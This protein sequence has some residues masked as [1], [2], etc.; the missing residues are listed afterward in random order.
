MSDDYVT[1]GGGMTFHLIFDAA[2]DAAPASFRTG[3]EAAAKLLS[4][5]IQN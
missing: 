4:Q 5:S 2:A 3:I 1:A